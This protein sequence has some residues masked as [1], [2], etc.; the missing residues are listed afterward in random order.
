MKIAI[1]VEGKTE[2]A[3]MPYLREYLKTHLAGTMP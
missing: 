2:K 1:I 3:F